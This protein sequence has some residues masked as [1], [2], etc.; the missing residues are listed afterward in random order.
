MI[1]EYN[2]LKRTWKFLTDWEKVSDGDRCLSVC[3]EDIWMTS[4]FS[5]S[6]FVRQYPVFSEYW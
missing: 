2:V 3:A 1:L 5:P 4:V 6:S